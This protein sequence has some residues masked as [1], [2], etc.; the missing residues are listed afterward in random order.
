MESGDGGLMRI[1]FLNGYDV[2][3]P[4]STD[5]CL[6]IAKKNTVQAVTEMRLGER[7]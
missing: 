5:R 6:T 4:S 3:F 1:L 7:S 2:Q